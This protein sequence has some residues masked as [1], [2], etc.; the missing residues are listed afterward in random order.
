MTTASFTSIGSMSD[1]DLE[2]LHREAGDE[3][4]RR[5][6]AKQEACPHAEYEFGFLMSERP[7][8][9]QLCR[10]CYA[11]KPWELDPPT[12]TVSKSELPG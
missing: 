8:S 11:V 9:A 4:R 6:H 2:R 7:T 1:E 12:H 5:Y 10:K 3:I